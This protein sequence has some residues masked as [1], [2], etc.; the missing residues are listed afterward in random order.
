MACLVLFIGLSAFAQHPG[1]IPIP[2][3]M[4]WGNGQFV[5][6]KSASIGCENAS[7][8]PAAD[9]LAELLGKPT[10][11]KFKRKTGKGTIQLA[12]TTAGKP[13]SYTLTV[14][15]KGVKIL[16][17]TYAG[18]ISGI[19]TLR[20]L[21]PEDVES[22]DVLKGKRWSLPFVSITDEPRFGWRGMMLD[23][24]RHF[25]SKAE[26][27]RLLDVLALYKMNKFHWHL[28]DDQGWRIEIK[29]YPKLTSVGAWRH[30]NHQDS[31][32][33]Q[34]LASEDMPNF[35][36]D[37][38][39]VHQDANGKDV[40]G[41]F[42]T[43]Q[44]I[45]DIVDYAAVRGI[46]V[47]P[48]IDMPGHSMIVVEN[49]LD[50]S[51]FGKPTWGD[52]QSTPMC[53]GKDKVLEF[54]KDVWREVFDLFPSKY[55]HIGGDE[56]DF[57]NWKTCPDC[58]KRMKDHGLQTVQ[59]LQ[60]W[61]THYMEDFFNKNGKQMI[62]WDEIVEGGLSS[63]S[64]VMW[65]RSWTPEA[66]KKA[67]A[68]G[69]PVI[70][71]PNNYFY[72]DYV[73]GSTAIPK[74]YGFDPYGIGVTPAQQHLVLGVQ[75]NLWAEWVP[76]MNRVWYMGFPRMLAIAELGW[77]K[78]ARMN[79]DDFN[80]RL[81]PHFLRLQK[82]GVTYRIP[83]LEGFVERNS[84]VGTTTVKVSCPDPTAVIRYTTD[85]SVP[86][87]DS[88]LY[89]APITISESTNFIFRV[90]DPAGNKGDFKRCAYVKEDFAPA[91]TEAG[92]ADGLCAEWYDYAG[93]NCA[94]IDSVPLNGTYSVPDV[95]I[96]SA[97]KG[98]I[99]LIIT[100]FITVPADGIYTFSLLSDDGSTLKIDG[101]LVVDNDQE[102][103]P[104][105]LAGQKA[106]RKGPHR[107]A[108][109]YFDHNGGQ[110]K[111]RVLDEKGNEAKVSYSN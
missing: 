32:C 108:V 46:E 48:E 8:R 80:A 71:T 106:L 89:T 13:G 77:S 63:T 29:K 82:A 26:V 100:G 78:S 62:G 49:Y 35:T 6:K 12:L 99:G 101:Q 24:S 53:P 1:I 74:I 52:W 91:A 33:M 67:A 58:Q 85:G 2:E 93:A 57:T 17:N 11:Y 7:L 98:N 88:P 30:Y 103:S 83:D 96:P 66:P 97:C 60:A 90:F 79:L 36:I 25:F 5:L 10:G 40:Y 19:S 81:K 16:G 68:H 22:D 23:C 95:R 9:Y 42:Y 110:L 92:T 28:V 4:T 109:R 72:M 64:A 105:E 51:C 15:K 20:Q 86:Q 50:L 69:N 84:F 111:L 56:V 73:A 27:E 76:N 45:R 70:C 38:A 41:G 39:K 54:C 31:V 18:V 43:Q 104:K 59:Q 102:H 21:L 94:G 47:I 65:W 34:R 75:G 37:P 3:R 107:I 14:D 61:F 55:V 44:D 87:Q